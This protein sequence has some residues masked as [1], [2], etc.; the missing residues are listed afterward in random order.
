MKLN[1]DYNYYYGSKVATLVPRLVPR[2]NKQTDQGRERKVGFPVCVMHAGCN[3][4]SEASRSVAQSS[5][6]LQIPSVG[7]DCNGGELRF[8]DACVHL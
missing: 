8:T 1:Y 7:P 2:K 6:S 5:T 3:V 4:H